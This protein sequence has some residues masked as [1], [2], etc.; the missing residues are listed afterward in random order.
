MSTE[1]K[2]TLLQWLLK[3]VYHVLGEE[4]QLAMSN[5][6]LSKK[7][8]VLWYEANYSTFAQ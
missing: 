7:D 5:M 8:L 1:K 6:L 3:W 4:L 2:A